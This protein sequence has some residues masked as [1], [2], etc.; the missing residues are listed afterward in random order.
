MF[1]YLKERAGKLDGPK[2]AA[3]FLFE[4]VVVLLGVLAAQMLQERFQA[5]QAKSNFESNRAA[6]NL[7]LDNVGTALVQRGLQAECVSENLTRLITAVE[8][9][10]PLPGDIF[11]THPPKGAGELT[12]W[13]G[14][15]AAQT[16]KYLS[17]E[18]AGAYEFLALVAG[19]LRKA[20]Q[21]EE[22]DWATLAL[23]KGRAQDLGD[24]GRTQVLLAANNLLHAYEGWERAP[25]TTLRLMSLVGSQAQP[26]RILAVHQEGVPCRRAVL[27]GLSALELPSEERGT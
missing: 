19:D 1:A 12:I 22:S 3:I 11:T 10:Q 6:L 2:W 14:S 24:A 27:S 9:R 18:E 13:D 17:D 7:Q 8:A 4:F 26:G 21:R 16:R 25:A 23:A 20:A 5:Q 15:L